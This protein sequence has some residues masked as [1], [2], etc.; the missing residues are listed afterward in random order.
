M[1][2][3]P[4]QSN[5]RSDLSKAHKTI[6]ISNDERSNENENK[7]NII[8]MSNKKRRRNCK[9]GNER[10]ISNEMEIKKENENDNEINRPEKRICQELDVKSES[11]SFQSDISSNSDG[12]DNEL[13][14]CLSSLSPPMEPP[15]L[16]LFHNSSEGI[17]IPSLSSPLHSYDDDLSIYTPIDTNNDINHSYG[18]LSLPAFGRD[19]DSDF[20]SFPSSSPLPFDNDTNELISHKF[21]LST[22]DMPFA[23][24]EFM[25]E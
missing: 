10:K 13:S 11:N 9:E 6:N 21:S 3:I 25:Y 14:F 2:D 5:I 1:N 22:D 17:S 23:T 7:Q 19:G 20:H 12:F 18:S 15:S 16:E 8:S 4:N 24:R